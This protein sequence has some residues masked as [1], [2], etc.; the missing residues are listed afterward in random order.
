MGATRLYPDRKQMES[1]YTKIE[2]GVQ[3][4]CVLS[5]ELFNLCSKKKPNETGKP[6]R[7]YYRL[8]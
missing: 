3:Q 2:S 1:M 8:T 5:S 6:T 4:G 7:K